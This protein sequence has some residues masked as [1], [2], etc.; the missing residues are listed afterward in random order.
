MDEDFKK[1]AEFHGH[2]CLGLAIG[3]RVAKYAIAHNPRSADEELV[4]I[5]ENSSCSVDAIQWLL[6]CT[7]G[8][9]NLIFRDHG[10]QVFTFYSRNAERRGRALRICFNDDILSHMSSLRARTSG[11]ILTEEEQREMKRLR[12]EA[13]KAI[14]SAKDDDILSVSQVEVPEPEMARIYPSIRCQECGESFMEIRGRTANGKIL[15]IPCF[16][17]LTA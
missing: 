3:Y 12:E 14:L 1:A 13:I 4:C 11:K 9:G 17:R 2:V 7:F 16:D 10:K 15:C 5:A 6:G 8:K